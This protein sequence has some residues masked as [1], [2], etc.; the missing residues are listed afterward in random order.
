MGENKNQKVLE[1]AILKALDDV[2]LEGVDGGYDKKQ[3]AKWSGIA[4]TTVLAA[5]GLG[6]GGKKLYDRYDHKH[7]EV[8][9]EVAPVLPKPEPKPTLAPNEINKNVDNKDHF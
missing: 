1:E 3:I 4:A 8:A 7:P 2:E 6:Y 5:L 9:P